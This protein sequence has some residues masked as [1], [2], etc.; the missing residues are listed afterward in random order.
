MRSKG[1]WKKEKEK[2]KYNT[3]KIKKEKI[4]LQP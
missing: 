1:K 3:Q 4:Y 2:E